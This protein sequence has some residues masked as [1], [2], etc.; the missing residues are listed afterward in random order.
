MS[1][2]LLATKFRDFHPSP[3]V[4][5]G[6]SLIHI[7]A[8]LSTKVLDRLLKGIVRLPIVVTAEQIVEQEQEHNLRTQANKREI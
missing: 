5:S 4:P 3:A 2:A 1:S 6:V 7:P 8:N